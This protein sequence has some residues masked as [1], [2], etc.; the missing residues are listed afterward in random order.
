MFRECEEKALN[1]LT[2]IT[3]VFPFLN[4]SMSRLDLS[5]TVHAY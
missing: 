1:F 2:Q 4:E 5:F 3:T